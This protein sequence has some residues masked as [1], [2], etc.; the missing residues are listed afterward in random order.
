MTFHC[1]ICGE[2]STR[3][4][5]WCTRD[6]CVNHLCEKC[7][8]C[9]DCCEC[10]VPLEET[11]RETARTYIP[12]SQ[13]APEPELHPPPD[14]NQVREDANQVREDEPDPDVATEMPA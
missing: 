13:T 2:E 5:V 8:R 7:G 9:S 14:G 6:N 11:V 1:T 10:Q 3:I 4:C 12:H